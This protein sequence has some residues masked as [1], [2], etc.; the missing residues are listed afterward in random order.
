[1]SD[2]ITIYDLARELKLSPATISRGLK[3]NSSIS[4]N[5][6]SRIL[7]KA[8]ELGYRPNTFASNL[9]NKNTHTIG[10]IVPKLNSNFMS[11]ALAGME[12][13]ASK[14]NYN[15]IITQSLEKSEKEKINVQTMFNS[16]VDGLLIS[17]AYDTK[18]INHLQIFFNKK[19]PVVFFDRAYLSNDSTA[20]VIDNFKSAYAVTS[21]LAE[22]GCKRIM[23]VSGNLMRDIYSDRMEGYKTALQDHNLNF[24]NK[25]VYICDLSEQA[26]EEVANHILNMKVN[27]RPDGVFCANDTVAV[28]CMLALKEKG[29][30]IPRDI[31]FAGFNN[32]RIS[33]VIEPNLTTVNYSGYHIGEVAITNLL[34]QLKNKTSKSPSGKII[35]QSELLIRNSSLRIQQNELPVQNE[36]ER[37]ERNNNL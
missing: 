24:D 12:H 18:N 14:E 1:M 10:V 6:I 8:E 11:A 20:V 28:H 22:Q 15:L 13:I 21:H 29:I 27:M 34:N 32:D 9:R 2:E 7:K 35:L 33:K 30:S 37:K 4:K 17:L 25:L 31:A 26:G 36:H 19:I 5:T 23:H 3:K 16:R